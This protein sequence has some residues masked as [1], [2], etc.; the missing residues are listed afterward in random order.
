MKQAHRRR[1]DRESPTQSADLYALSVRG[2]SD[3]RA[4]LGWSIAAAILLHLVLFL[5]QLPA[6]PELVVED[7]GPVIEVTWHRIKAPVIERP[8]TVIVDTTRLLPVP[9]PD[10]GDPEPPPPVGPRIPGTGDVANP[11][12]I[13]STKVSPHYPEV[14]RVARV[15]AVVTLQAVIT[16]TGEV[17]DIRVL[18]VDRPNLGF[19][20]AAIEAVRQW[21]Y[22]PATSGGRPVDVYFTIRVSFTLL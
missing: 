17:T 21:R 16:R 8:E 4:I 7:H 12:L 20:Q 22:K 5:V 13:A 15:S 18:A 19:E 3:D 9:D 1:P 6:R 10:P 14:A 11:V 2:R